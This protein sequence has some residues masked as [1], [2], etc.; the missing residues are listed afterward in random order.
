MPSM[1][2]SVGPPALTSIRIRRG[3]LQQL[4]VFLEVLGGL[5]VLAL[6]DAV[7]E[8]LGL[9]EGA[10]EDG[11]GE[12]VALD[13]E[14][15]VPPHHFQSDDAESLSGHEVFLP[16]RVRVRYIQSLRIHDP[17]LITGRH[18]R[19]HGSTTALCGLSN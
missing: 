1:V 8:V 18:S 3:L 4:D 5:E 13:V 14:G 6:G 16:E 12:A 11:D 2:A 15:D 19:H 10:V 7:D 9:G 17:K